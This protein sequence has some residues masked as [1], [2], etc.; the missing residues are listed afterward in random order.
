MS[1][2]RFN[3]IYE[4]KIEP[5]FDQDEARRTLESLFEFDA[6]IRADLNNGQPVMLGKSMDAATADSFKQALA[7]AG[8]STYLLAENDAVINA[9][10][11][12]RRLVVD[13]RATAPRR[14]RHRSGAILPDRRNGEDRRR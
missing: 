6:G 11:P 14:A 7:G 12:S 2:T 13:R 3:L 5:G 8:V 1:A 10:T 4:G 9:E